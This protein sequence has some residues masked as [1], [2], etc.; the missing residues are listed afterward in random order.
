MAKR[1]VT[2]TH[3]KDTHSAPTAPQGSTEF[4]YEAHGRVGLMDS[5]LGGLSV[6][7][8]LRSLAPNLALD[9]Y[10]DSR[11]CPYG[12]RTPG[13]IRQRLLEIT[14]HLTQQGAEVLVVA[15]NTA[16]AA[17]LEWLR[18]KRSV[19]VV[20]MEPAVKPA[21]AA[22][23]NGKVGVLATGVTLEAQRFANLVERFAGGIQVFTEAA[24]E[25]VGLVEAGCIH[26]PKVERIVAQKVQPLLE[27]GVD[28]LV[29][30]CTHFPF[31][32]P[33][34]SAVVGPRVKLIETGP[35]VAA[36]TVRVHRE[37]TSP[38]LVLG[39]EPW[40]KNT[41]SPDRKSGKAP[42]TEPLHHPG[43]RLWSSGHPETT[44]ARARILLGD[45]PI[46]QGDPK[47]ATRTPIDS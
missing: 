10:A 15:C 3:D 47:R 7:K 26:G 18:T 34:L 14:E 39:G 45:L 9:Y 43:V 19:P 23:R 4:V 35:S 12:L 37:V 33:I 38:P 24:P 8:A 11:Y 28:T 6:V 31:L 13:F 41:D 22:T 20:G 40:K 1:S 16:S 2:P 42:Q 32:A 5:G 25:L 17:G 27:A 44:L 30:G 46:H 21:T 36:Q 29:L